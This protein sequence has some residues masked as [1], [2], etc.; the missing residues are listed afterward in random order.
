MDHEWGHAS[1]PILAG[2]LLIQLADGSHGSLLV[3]YH[4]YSGEVCW[5]TARESTGSWTT[6]VLV[7][8][9]VGGQARWELVVNG[10]GSANGSPG[11]VIA[12]D[13]NTGEELWRVRGTTDIP[14]P[15][16]II[17]GGLVVSTS[18]ANGPILAIRPGGDGDVTESHVAWRQPWGGAYV[19][20]GIIEAGRLYLI[21]DGGVLRCLDLAHGRAI[22][23]ERLH[24]SCSASL[25]AGDGKLF[26][27]S[28]RGDVHVFKIGDERQLLAVNSLRERCLATPAI[29]QGEL[30]VRTER[31]LYCFANTTPPMAE[32]P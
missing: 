11:F 9:E 23:E 27:L 20:T 2:D 14:C 22:W 24:D 7:K 8:A 6:P 28:E 26:A 32:N 30:F 19:P 5:S 12:Y 25:V 15:T 21:S 4:R 31:R 18:G 13:P 3:A 10:T 1:S 17:G 29:T 16:A